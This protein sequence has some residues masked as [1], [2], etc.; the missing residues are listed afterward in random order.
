MTIPQDNKKPQLRVPHRWVVFGVVSS[1]Y[2]FVYFHRVSTSVIA[3]D[4]LDAFQTNATALGFMSS[5]YFYVYAIEQPLVGHLSDVLGPRRVVGFWSLVAALGCIVFGLS[6]SIGWASVGRGLIGF[7]VGGV[8]VPAMKAFSQWFKDKEFATM[9]GMLLAVGNLGAVVATTP[10][11]WI[12][13]SCG[14]RLSFFIIG[15]V[16]LGLA[17]VTLLLLQDYPETMNRGFSDVPLSGGRQKMTPGSSIRP[18]LASLR[19]WVF[20]VVFFGVFGTFLT[21]QGL[22]AT[23]SLMST[24]KLD[25]LYASQLNMLLP[26][27]FILGA[28]F[29]GLLSDRVFHNKVRVFISLL[30]IL[31]CMWFFLA[32]GGQT[33]ESSLM[34]PLLLIMGGAAGGFASTLW[35]LIRETTHPHILG[36]TSGL[37]NPAPFLGVATLQVVTGAI[38]DRVGRGNDLYPPVAYREA[39]LVCALIMAV[40]LILSGCFR[41]ILGGKPLTRKT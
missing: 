1:V 13:H 7:G 38:L 27:G 22:W 15:G 41:K 24:L 39:F 19:F 31:T 9:T 5:M 40:C 14:W 32:L 17:F 37:L 18:V 35:S 12:A 4:L 26:I 3:P 33:I 11:A 6:P 36:L 16:T 20:A 21:Y 29:I 2:F 28:P 8:Y 34:I 23:P 10:L 30:A 25:R